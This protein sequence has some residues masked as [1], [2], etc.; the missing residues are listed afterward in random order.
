[1]KLRTSLYISFVSTD[2]EV[3]YIFIVSFIYFYASKV[4]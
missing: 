3:N 4:T 2:G 1:M